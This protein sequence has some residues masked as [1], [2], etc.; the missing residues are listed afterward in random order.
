MQTEDRIF[1]LDK[2]PPLAVMNCSEM[3]CDDQ[4][5]DGLS[6]KASLFYGSGDNDA[7]T[8]KNTYLTLTPAPLFASL[9]FTL[10]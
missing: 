9:P 3:S 8:P 7:L 6:L 1:L 10:I 4:T 5:D 2:S